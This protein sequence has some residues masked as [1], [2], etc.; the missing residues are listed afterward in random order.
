MCGVVCVC[1]CVCVWCVV[2]ALS[3]HGQVVTCAGLIAVACDDWSVRVF[4]IASRRRVR[5][6]DG[7]SNRITDLCFSV[8]ARLLV[9]AAMDSCVRVW[10]LPT[11]RCADW[12]RFEHPV[13]SVALSPTGEFLATAHVD[14]GTLWL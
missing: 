9:S 5:K 8:D 3:S 14:L 10:D 13:T 7:H 1:V 6:F 4:D 11:S 2:G 12:M